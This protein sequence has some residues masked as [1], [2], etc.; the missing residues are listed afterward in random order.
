M[1]TD[2]TEDVLVEVM[3]H[4]IDKGYRVSCT[5][6]PVALAVSRALGVSFEEGG[7]AHVAKDISV[8]DPKN[9]RILRWSTPSSVRMFIGEFD[10]GGSP[11]PF[12]FILSANPRSY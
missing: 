3:Q 9:R 8:H 12:T 5:R 1:K 2:L 4:D 10:T 6:C 11:P 7:Y